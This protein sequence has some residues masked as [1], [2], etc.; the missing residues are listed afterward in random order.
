MRIK[1][2]HMYPEISILNPQMRYFHK[3]VNT[4]FSKKNAFFWNM[5]SKNDFLGKRPIDVA[6]ITDSYHNEN[7]L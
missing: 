2:L 1:I 4:D 6:Y 7:L 3:N 5:R